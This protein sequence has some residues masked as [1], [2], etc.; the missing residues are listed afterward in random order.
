[1]FLLLVYNVSIIWP[2]APFLRYEHVDIC[3]FLLREGLILPQL[4]ALYLFDRRINLR[5]LMK[6]FPLVSVI[7]N[8]LLLE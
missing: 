1:M 7:F 4:T 2:N 5:T 6:I 3:V 8:Y